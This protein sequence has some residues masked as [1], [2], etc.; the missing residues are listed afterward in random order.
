MI[1]KVHHRR[2]THYVILY[3]GG[4]VVCATLLL[5]AVWILPTQ[6][7]SALNKNRS[8]ASNAA[9]YAARPASSTAPV[10][11]LTRFAVIG[12][13]GVSEP[14]AKRVADLVKSW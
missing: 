11:E 7:Y 3:M 8:I 2:W 4:V 6:L 10:R 1:K 13:Y 14:D 5:C 12:D 9:S